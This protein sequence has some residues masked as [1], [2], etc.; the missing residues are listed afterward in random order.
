M[1]S[2]YAETAR[3]RGYEPGTQHV[4]YVL[5]MQVQDTDEKAREAGKGFLL[6][7]VGVGQVPLPTDYM[8]PVGYSSRDPRYLRLRAR[9]RKDPLRLGGGFA[10]IDDAGYQTILN[11]NR[12]VVGNPDTV[13][14]KL[15]QVLS[16]VRPGILGVWTNDGSTSHS[17][18][19]RCL[20]L[21]GKEVLPA[22]REI[23]EE[24]ELRD[25]FQTPP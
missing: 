20:Q 12:I 24:L 14:N 23:G 16:V 2:I 5:R 6:G 13:I 1:K 7:N 10:K 4:G 25:P 9:I 17:D 11:S 8:F 15:R 22:L 19:M 18:T 21:M 3:A